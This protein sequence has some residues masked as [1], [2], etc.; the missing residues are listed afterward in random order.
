M[1]RKKQVAV[2]FINL[3]KTDTKSANLVCEKDIQNLLLKLLN[4]TNKWICERKM[5]GN[6]ILLVY[7]CRRILGLCK[8]FF[9]AGVES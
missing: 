2:S 8:R 7:I 3:T 9:K 1:V 5:R 4:I 6:E